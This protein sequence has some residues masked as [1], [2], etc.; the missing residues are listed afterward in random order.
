[1]T[2][3]YNIPAYP[4][5]VGNYHWG[6]HWKGPWQ[7]WTIGP[8]IDIYRS[9]PF[10]FAPTEEEN[11]MPINTDQI[12]RGISIELS[13]IRDQAC[14]LTE[15]ADEGG[16]Q[17]PELRNQAAAMSQLYINTALAI[18]HAVGEGEIEVEDDDEDFDPCAESEGDCD[19]CEYQEECHA[20]NDED[21]EDDEG[22]CA[23]CTERATCPD[24]EPT[25]EPEPEPTK[26]N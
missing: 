2:K 22:G 5:R 12:E 4:S 19:K 25:K 10:S 20:A 17:S 21:D 13:R 16:S 8:A 14:K 26:I 6:D 18:L 15:L 7:D 9:I 1:M 23:T 11:Q 3:L 24:A